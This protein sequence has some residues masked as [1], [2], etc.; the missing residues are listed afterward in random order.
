MYIIYFKKN[1][2]ELLCIEVKYVLA[3]NK[4]EINI[5]PSSTVLNKLIGGSGV[6]KKIGKEIGY[7]DFVKIYQEWIIKFLD[8]ELKIRSQL[9]KKHSETSK[10]IND[11]L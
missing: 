2:E 5:L 8:S 6:F 3:N 4:Y 1:K 9:H 11:F 7:N 10:H